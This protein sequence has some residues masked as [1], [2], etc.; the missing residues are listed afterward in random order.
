[1]TEPPFAP[2]STAVRRDV[3]RNK[4]W[5]AT[6]NRVLADADGVVALACWP[7]VRMLAPATWTHWLRT[8][9][10][11]VRKQGVDD[12]AAG[13]WDLDPWTWQD[14]TLVSEFRSGQHFSV[15]RYLSDRPATW[16]VNFELPYRRT[17]IGIDTMDLLLDL[18]VEPDLS[19]YRWKDEDEYAQ[20]RRIGLID[21][22][23]HAEVTAARDQVLALVE[24]AEGP[25]AQDRSGFVADPAWP[26][27]VLPD[28]AL[29]R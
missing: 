7:G 21:D 27:P 19:G 15:H 16:Y 18:E 28:D 12:L 29:S 2:G 9:D 10:D 4:V 6:P 11:V 1:L 5:T 14:T 17:A 23:T 26:L 22:A 25:F 24:A 3:R 13:R 20:G 8:G